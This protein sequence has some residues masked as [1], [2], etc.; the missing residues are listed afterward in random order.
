MNE[1]A[2]L[3]I[4]LISTN[5]QDMFTVMRECPTKPVVECVKSQLCLHGIDIVDEQVFARL[6]SNLHTVPITMDEKLEFVTLVTGKMPARNKIHSFFELILTY[7]SVELIKF[8]EKELRRGSHGV[9]TVSEFDELVSRYLLFSD[10]PMARKIQLAQLLVWDIKEPAQRLVALFKLLEKTGSI[11]LVRALLHD[12]ETHV[13]ED[14]RVL[15]KLADYLDT[16]DIP[17]Y[18]KARLHKALQEQGQTLTRTSFDSLLLELVANNSAENVDK[19]ERALLTC[20]HRLIDREKDQYAIMCIVGMA[21][22]PDAAVARLERAVAANMQKPVPSQDHLPLLFAQLGEANPEI[23]ERIEACF[24][25]KTVD[26][27][28]EFCD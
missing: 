22:L 25:E 2:A 17:D 14:K 15:H 1:S 20:N 24:R 26:T 8:I 28:E 23:V 10:C 4:I 19:I 9:E 12:L 16:T 13:V 5:V 3:G 18:E 7:D 27:F 6:A 11:D 21:S